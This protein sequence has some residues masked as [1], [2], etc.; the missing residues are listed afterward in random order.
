MKNALQ[1]LLI[2][3]LIWSCNAEPRAISYGKDN[4]H[5]C[6]MKLMDP[7]YGA[8]VVTQKGKI[9]IFD[10][11]NCLMSFLESDEVSQEDIKNI[12]VADYKNPESLIDA[13]V[14]FYLKSD[15]FQ[16]P[17]ASNII[18]FSDYKTLESYKSEHGGVYLAWGELV[19]QFK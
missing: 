13:T 18:A 3:L 5:H 1:I 8:E 12:L 19:T 15:K 10:D 6:K 11:V 4:C 9:F 2:S 14:A 7:V 16:T 17:M